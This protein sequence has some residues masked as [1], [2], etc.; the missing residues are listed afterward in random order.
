MVHPKKQKL[1]IGLG[2]KIKAYR[3]WRQTSNGGK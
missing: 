2:K 3:E 1:I